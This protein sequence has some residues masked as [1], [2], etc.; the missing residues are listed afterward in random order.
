MFQ[1]IPSGAYKPYVVRAIYEWCADEGLTPYLT[2]FVNNETRVPMAYVRDGQ[3]TLN[4]SMNATKDLHIDNQAITFSARFG[5]KPF[6]LYIPMNAVLGIYARESTEGL[7]FEP[8]LTEEDA[9]ETETSASE[10]EAYHGLHAVETETSRITS[11]TPEESGT[12]SPPPKEKPR[13]KVVK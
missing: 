1:L 11:S 6:S 4:I 3:I 5:G 12:P 7:F 10:E 8:E 9:S 13:L 2:V